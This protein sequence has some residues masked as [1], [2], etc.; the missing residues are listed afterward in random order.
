MVLRSEAAVDRRGQAYLSLT[1]QGTD[2]GRIEARWWRYPYPVEQRPDVG[3]VCHFKGTIDTYNGERQLRIVAARVATEV[4]PAIFVRSTRRSGDELWAELDAR[5][6]R[7]DDGM[8]A[9]MRM[10]LDGEAGERFRTWPAAHQRHAAVRHGLLAHSLHVANIARLLGEAYGPDGLL[11]DRDLVLAA[12]LLHDIGKVRTLPPVAG[13]AVSDEARL[14]DHVTLSVL[15]VKAAAAQAD[16][17]IEPGRLDKL[18]HAIA[19]HHGR[20][21]WGAPV[22]P[23]TV[24]AL[25]VHLADLV[26]S[27]L[28]LRSNEEVAK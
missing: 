3:Q 11:Y 6:A 22:E 10:A 18:L 20:Q 27:Q 24:E 14:F 1:L 28:W 15:M 13:A 12:S 4:D 16:P 26:E 2:G 23:Q 21:E 9:L 8:A 5:I 19:A 17:P 7:L 25:L